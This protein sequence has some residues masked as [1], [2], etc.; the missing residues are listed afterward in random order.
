MIDWAKATV[1]DREPDRPRWTKE[2]IHICKEA[3]NQ[4]EGC[5]QLSHMYDRFLDM[6]AGHRVK[7]QKNSVV[8][9]KV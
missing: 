1:I 5:Y 2:S 4:D 8:E 9:G 3:M 7:I 6:T